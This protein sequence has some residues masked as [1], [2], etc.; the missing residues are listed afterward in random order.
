MKTQV[1]WV[2]ECVLGISGCCVVRVVVVYLGVY[3]LGYV[4]SVCITDGVC[5]REFGGHFWV[6]NV[7]L[8]I[9]AP[10]WCGEDEN[11]ECVWPVECLGR[12]TWIAL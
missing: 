11:I 8:D 7:S 12:C 2:V 10:E 1:I 9:G 3:V 5:E 4:V 6:R